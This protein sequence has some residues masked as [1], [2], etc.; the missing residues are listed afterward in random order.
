MSL[1]SAH[2][3]KRVCAVTAILGATLIV[4]RASSVAPVTVTV[5]GDRI[6]VKVNG[7]VFT[8]LHTAK[9]PRKL[10]L[11]PVM[12]ASGKRVT[13]AFP[14]EQIRGESTDHPHQRGIWI[15]AE[16]V[17]GMDFW[18]NEPSDNN[19]KAGAVVL[20]GVSDVHSGDAEG[21]FTIRAN[22]MSA[23]GEN[24]IV[25]T[26]MM[27][28]SEPSRDRRIIDIDLRLMAKSLVT[29]ADNHD[30]ILGLRLATEFEEANGGKAINAEGVT[31]WERLRGARSP[32]VDWHA[33]V[34]GEDVG[35]AVMD[36][37]TN[38]RFPTPWH[39]RDY[40]LLFASPFASRDYQ[41]SAPDGRVTLKPGDELRLRYRILVHSGAV[42]MKAAFQDFAR[43]AVAR[44]HDSVDVTGQAARA[45]RVAPSVGR[46]LDERDVA[47]LPS[48]TRS[49]TKYALL[50]PH[51]RQ[52]IGLG[53]DFQ[54]SMRLSINAGSYRHTGYMLDGV[55]TYDWIYAN[56]PQVTV[57]PGAV[58]EMKVLTG[59]ASAQYGM[60]TTG[61]LSI[62]TVS[63]GD[64][65]RGDAF[66]LA[67]P[68]DAQARPPLATMDVP[69][70]RV[71]GGGRV[72]GPVAV[73]T[74]FFAAYEG[75]D[76]RRGAY[77][78]SPRPGFFTGTT[79]EQSGIAR[80]D[81]AS[82][83]NRTLTV[84]VNGSEYTTDNANDRV[85]GFNQASFG[86][87]SRAQSLGGQVSHGAIFRALAND[88]RVSFTA[89]TP[90]SATPLQTS[91][92]AVR[93]N[94]STEGFSTSNW[95]HARAFQ[96]GDTLRWHR[97]RHEI[98]FGGEVV[99]VDARDYSVTPLGT[100][101]F[102][103]GPPVAGE[104]P[105]TYTQTFGTI[106]L[107]YGQTQA[108]AFVQ[109]EWRLSDRLTVS[110]GL[111]Y[112]VQSITDDRANVAPRLAI[113][114]DLTGNGRTIIRSGA[115]VTFD[116]Y[117]MY[118]IRRFTSLGPRSP[119]ATYTWSW[120]D[121]GFPTFPESFVTAPQ[122]KAAGARDIMVPAEH[123][124]NPRGV[125][126]S[127]GVEREI[128]RGVTVQAAAL[129]SHTTRQM[130]VDDLNHPAPFERTAANQVRT[131]P[132]ANLTRPYSTYDGVVVRDVARIVNTAESTYRS[133]DVGLTSRIGDRARLGVR[134]TWSSSIAYSMFY[135]D[136]NSGVP[137]EWWPDWDRFERGPSDFHQPH[138][139]I[140]DGSVRVPLDTQISVVVTA[141]SG[142]SVNPTTG[143]DNNGDS[144]PVDRPVGFGRN[145]FRGPAQL[146]LDAAAA[147]RVR[148]GARYAVEARVEVFNVLNRVNPIKVNG[149]YGEGPSPLPTFLAPVAGVTNVDPARQVQLSA[150]FL[151]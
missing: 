109:D 26:R 94:Y 149:I 88:L 73:G 56:S 63:G 113:A 117:Y 10:Y 46:T 34:D 58:R 134:Y 12:T 2:K 23:A 61:V 17:S 89:Y 28:F 108:S 101:T 105:L 125:Q 106:D 65:L 53:A 103:P 126:I 68:H 92:Q 33:T 146:N 100:Y 127:F 62:A 86:R 16:Q 76:Q 144:Y 102:A 67:K 57:P 8:T 131:P 31:G 81:R 93:P 40:A 74:Y 116:Q 136:A 25:E 111:R 1:S 95:V 22:W 129:Q 110:S 128:C 15:G 118:L 98:T 142:L 60:S 55:S 37:P 35:V 137:N 42:D 147:K 139:L 82:R 38:F 49:T 120:G 87:T 4:V 30:A 48:L 45:D 119:Q 77:I 47:E 114:W 32:W 115:G 90:D 43:T 145:S 66:V 24:P 27:T 140:A 3:L 41:P 54:D 21:C 78:Q 150:R 44:F 121:P 51:V 52:V 112:E 18:E 97:G 122:G 11:H 148:L 79:R 124:H 132:Q 39:V 70:E 135:A 85:A 9:G 29:F 91:T 19:P 36:A 80:V 71:N 138:R 99:R 151:F 5:T 83:P 64:A 59:P 6:D 141:A 133:L 130:R 69:N 20:A 143:R 50:D 123:L 13:R 75:G 104:H 72:G 96:A 107:R 7:N 14:M 84:R